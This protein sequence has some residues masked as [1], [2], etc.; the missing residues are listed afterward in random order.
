MKKIIKLTETDINKIVTKILI[1]QKYA[2]GQQYPNCSPGLYKKGCFSEEIKKVQSCLGIKPSYG[3]F[4][5]KTQQILKDK[6]PDKKFYLRFTDNDINTICSG[7]P[8]SGEIKNVFVSDTIN[9]DYLKELDFSKLNTNGRVEGIVDPGTKECAEF[10]NKFSDKFGFVG[11][12]WDAYIN[13]ALGT[14]I[15]SKFKGLDKNQIKTAINLWFK[16]YKKGGGKEN[17]SN[18]LDVKKF[19]GSLIPKGTSTNL[20]LDDIVGIYNPNS[21]HHEEAFYQGGKPW[22]TEKNGK[23]AAGDTIKRGDAWG[24]NTHIGIVGAIKNGVPL[25]FHNVKGTVISE[26]ASNLRIAWVKRKGGTN[27]INPQAPKK[28]FLGL[29]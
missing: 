27:P 5:P 9:P 1:E 22:F 19:V 13:G 18:M 11:N 29:F 7:K 15:Y 25:I 10:V 2:S 17:G 14:T 12:A 26:P 20:E 8:N 4:G 3:N 24:M 16:L 23:M 21:S 28:K 6:F